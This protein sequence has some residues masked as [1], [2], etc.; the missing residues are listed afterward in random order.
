GC[1][2]AQV[3]S[4]AS[5]A[6]SSA[7]R[8]PGATDNTSPRSPQSGGLRPPCSGPARPEHRPAA[9]S[10]RSLQAC[11][12]PCHCSPPGCQRH[13][14][15]RTTS[16]GVDHSNCEKTKVDHIGRR[17]MP[18]KLCPKCHGQRTISCPA[19]HGTGK[20][21]IANTSVSD[22]EERSKLT[23]TRSALDTLVKAVPD[24]LVKE[25]VA[26]N[27]RRAPPTPT[28]PESVIDVLVERVAKA[29]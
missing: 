26:D 12:L 24:Q 14:S 20:K 13:T 9:V 8:T 4:G 15:S 23:M 17:T 21:T 16:M 11:I 29:D 7:R 25:I 6:R 18:R 10:R 1:S 5:P 27:Y 28:R 2:Q 3:P 22:C 19:C